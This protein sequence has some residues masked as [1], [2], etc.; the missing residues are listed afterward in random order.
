MLK[1]CVAK[2]TNKKQNNRI[3]LFFN[4]LLLSVCILNPSSTNYRFPSNMFIV[5]QIVYHP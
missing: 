1:I 4:P 2:I 3:V 5:M